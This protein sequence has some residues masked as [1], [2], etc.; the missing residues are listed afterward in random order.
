M[1]NKVKYKEKLQKVLEDIP[2]KTKANEIVTPPLPRLLTR[3]ML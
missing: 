2:K 1:K 3:K